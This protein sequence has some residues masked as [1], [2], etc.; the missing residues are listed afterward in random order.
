[1]EIFILIN[2]S[3]KQ[4]SQLQFFCEF[5]WLTLPTF[6]KLVGLAGPKEKVSEVLKRIKTI[7]FLLEYES[8]NDL[9]V[10]WKNHV[11]EKSCFWVIVQ[12]LPDQN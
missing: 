5:L 11:W 10:F 3:I 2:I 4:Y 9:K 6:W 8:T 12:K 1:M 7:Y